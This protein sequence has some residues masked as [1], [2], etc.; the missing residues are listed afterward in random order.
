MSAVGRGRLAGAG[1]V[2][3]IDNSQPLCHA[4]PG[5]HCRVRLE[6]G[7]TSSACYCRVRKQQ[8]ARMVA[9][10]TPASLHPPSLPGIWYL[11]SGVPYAPPAVV[12]PPTT[13]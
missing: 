8:H 10:L 2:T 9:S 4:S 11:L 6:A 12:P 13:C 5:C 7:T 1:E 3:F